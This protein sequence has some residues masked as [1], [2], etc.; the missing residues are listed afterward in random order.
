MRKN[1]I[2]TVA[3]VKIRLS[4]M[5]YALLSIMSV[6]N[7]VYAEALA[8]VSSL[9]ST[10]TPQDGAVQSPPL[11]STPPIPGDWT[12]TFDEEFENYFLDP[13][14]WRLGSHYLGIQKSM[15]GTNSNNIVVQNGNLELR[16]EK[17]PVVF[18]SK[19]FAYSSGEISTFR[20]FRQTYGY[21]EARIK[22]DISPGVW[23]AFWLN[24]DRGDYGN[25]NV[26]HQSFLRFNL[27]GFP[28]GV[29]KAM[30]KLKVTDIANIS[31][32]T[33]QNEPLYNVSIHQLL[34]NDWAENDITWATKPAYNPAWLKQFSGGV[35]SEDK[36]N[37]INVGEDLVIDVTDYIN[38]Q[39]LANSHAGFAII[40]SFEKN[41]Q[42]SFGSKESSIEGD[43][44][45]LEI[46]GYD[47]YPTDDA[48]VRAGYHT[49]TNFGDKA[50]LAVRDPYKFNSYN[51]DGGVEIDIFESQGV[52]EG[53]LQHAMHWKT[54]RG[55]L[56]H[57]V[58]SERIPVSPT[59]DDYHTYGLY[60]EPGRLTFYID[61]VVTDT[62]DNE[63][64]PNI[65]AYLLLSYNLGGW[66][67]GWTNGQHLDGFDNRLISDDLLPATMYVDYVRAWSGTRSN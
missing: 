39:I 49:F 2:K 18:G 56:R 55:G 14:K 5:C 47:V 35:V 22:Y 26:S 63:N 62:F 46:D 65:G 13:S 34:S 57:S 41:N 40:D 45:R 67:S 20:A 66:D 12:L 3:F 16:A 21:F 52:W 29:S 28:G 24:P 38:N 30:L 37:E 59:A 50:T 51:Y 6:T 25:E 61:G 1:S 36:A 43:R 7:V 31:E 60:W 33:A 11:E 53:A 44:P 8:D 54:H 15:A 27:E 17:T 42:V 48:Y 64:V 58:H 19:S 23:P 4:L 9:L 10:S 32:A